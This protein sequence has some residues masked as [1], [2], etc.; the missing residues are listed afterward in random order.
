MYDLYDDDHECSEWIK[1]K[2]V[3][4][5]AKYDEDRLVN[6]I[7]L[8]KM[9]KEPKCVANGKVGN[10]MHLTESPPS[11]G[12]DYTAVGW[13]NTEDDFYD[14]DDSFNEGLREVDLPFI[15]S[16]ECYWSPDPSQI[17]AGGHTDEKGICLGDSGGPFLHKVDGK[18]TQLGV[19]SYVSG[20]GCT[21]APMVFTSV[22][23]YRSWLLATAAGED[24]PPEDSSPEEPG[25]PPPPEQTP[26]PTTEPDSENSGQPTRTDPTDPTTMPSTEPSSPETVWVPVVAGS[27]CK[28]GDGEELIESSKK[29]E[30]AAKELGLS[31]KKFKTKNDTKYAKGCSYRDHKKTKK[32][33]LVF[34]EHTRGKKKKNKKK[35][36][37]VC[38]EE[39]AEEDLASSGQEGELSK[40]K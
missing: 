34:N 36:K 11:D 28:A 23:H 7:C 37:A 26:Q 29:C 10:L 1:V 30:N 18:L 22:H 9:T 4:C 16:D 24:P 15:P 17:C 20:G 13:G 27:Q 32:R 8:L 12:S 3:H 5:H 14:G 40:V 21:A 25:A 39:E 38:M 31:Y 35:F 33:Q 6:D 19:A 2:S